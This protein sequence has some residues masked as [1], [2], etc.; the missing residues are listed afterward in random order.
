MEKLKVGSD[1]Q[2]NQNAQFPYQIVTFIDNEPVVDEPVYYS[3]NG[4]Y[5]QVALKRRFALNGINEDMLVE[6]VRSFFK[7]HGEIIFEAGELVKPE[8]MPV[9]VIDIKNQ[10][11]LR[12]LH[13]RLIDEL[14]DA[15]VSRFPERDGENYYA[16]ITAEHEGRL[17]IPVDDYIQR[18]LRPKNIWLLKDVNGPNSQAYIK[19]I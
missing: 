2:S 3:K 1:L 8:R 9:R 12:E 11:E 10:I 14:K 17:V 7:R 19:I 13:S 15:I 4:W 5:P 6:L 18:T 16:H